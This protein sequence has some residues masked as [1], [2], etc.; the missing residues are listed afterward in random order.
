MW[1]PVA[2]K[3]LMQVRGGDFYYEKLREDDRYIVRMLTHLPLQCR[4]TRQASNIQDLINTAGYCTD[5]FKLISFK[6]SDVDW[7]GVKTALQKQYV[8][9]SRKEFIELENTALVI[10]RNGKKPSTTDS[11]LT[12]ESKDTSVLP[13]DVQLIFGLH[14]DK[15]IMVTS[16]RKDDGTMLYANVDFLSE[17]G[18][19]VFFENPL[20]MFPRHKFMATSYTY[21]AR[22]FYCFPLGVD[23]YGP[24]DRIMT[25]YRRTQSPRAF[26]LASAQAAGFPVVRKECKVLDIVPLGDGASY[27]TT[28][29]VYDAEFPHTKLSVGTV[30]KEGHVIGGSQLYNLIGPEEQLP[31]NITGLELDYAIPVPGLVAP[32]SE[33]EITDDA[34]N[35]RPQLRGT[36][37]ALQ[38]YWD[39]VEEKEKLYPRKKQLPKTANGVQFFRDELCAGR[40]LIAHINKKQMRRDMQLKLLAF[41]RR[42]MPIGAVLTVAPMLAII[43]EENLSDV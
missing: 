2:E 8:S 14:I 38:A 36:K 28:D 16:I 7:Y 12:A 33:I 42:E 13:E 25:Y 37:E 15:D 4:I 34:G 3:I 32:N 18:R 10:L 1:D 40:C 17:F 43:S 31:L 11:N 9:F 20:T 22:S 21:R 26:Y 23:V 41:L 24:V 39:Y 5:N 27:I 30:L 35:Y 29:G 19:I 6:D